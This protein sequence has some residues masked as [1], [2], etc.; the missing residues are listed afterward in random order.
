MEWDEW[1]PEDEDEEYP[2]DPAID[3]VKDALTKFFASNQGTVF[4]L[5]QLQV[6]FEKP[7]A[8]FTTPSLYFIG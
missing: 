3:G 5:T 1:S 6:T 2:R 7:I 8:G 4:Y